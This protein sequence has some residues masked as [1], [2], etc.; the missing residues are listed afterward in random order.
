MALSPRNTCNTIG[1]GCNLRSMMK[2]DDYDVL[3]GLP[4]SMP[5]SG[6]DLP[7]TPRWQNFALIASVMDS[8]M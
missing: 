3:T 5:G 7:Q 1:Y 8:T 6:F 4:P 2:V